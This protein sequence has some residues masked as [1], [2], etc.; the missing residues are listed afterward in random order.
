[1]GLKMTVIGVFTHCPEL[2]ARVTWMGDAFR[3]HLTLRE[4]V[5]LTGGGRGG[6]VGRSQEIDDG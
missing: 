5:Y 3:R 2:L 6:F 1:M 4:L